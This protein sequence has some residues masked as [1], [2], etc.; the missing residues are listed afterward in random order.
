MT[1]MMVPRGVDQVI[2]N[3]KTVGPKPEPGPMGNIPK[4]M[5]KKKG[6]ILRE[7]SKGRL[8]SD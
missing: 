7:V 4:G 2:Q 3:A 8:V 1:L 5:G 6:R